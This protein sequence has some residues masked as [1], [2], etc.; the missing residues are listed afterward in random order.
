MIGGPAVVAE[1]VRGGFV[2]GQHCGSVVG[3]R[4]DGTVAVSV[5]RPDEPM[6]PRSSAKPLQAIGML[7]AG[8]VVDDEE[9]AV[10]CASHSGEPGHL[11]VVRRLLSGAGLSESDLDNTAGMPLSRS[12]RRDLTRLGIGPSSLLANCSGKH[13]GMLAT[14]VAAGWP[15]A[16]YRDPAHP[17]QLSLRATI[18]D[19]TGDA[20]TAAV[21]DGCGAALFAVT[22]A[23]LARAFARLATAP[24]A[25]PERQCFEAMRSHPW[26][27]GGTG[28]DVTS[29]ISGVPGLVGKDGAEGVYAIALQDGRAAAV[30]IDDG[31]ERARLP[32]M[33]RALRSLGI[34][35]PTVAEFATTPVMG[36]GVPV[37]EVRPVF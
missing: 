5:G 29:L 30:K 12:A 3:L 24:A 7:R 18:E 1:V 36:H 31:A 27:V 34:D 14:C 19:L 22:L 17:L 37:G 32:V 8:L 15:T 35:D 16:G 11:D 26:L 2:E 4:G 23:G 28:R 20:V 21:V 6:L 25:T 9:L 33:V 10:I 13:A